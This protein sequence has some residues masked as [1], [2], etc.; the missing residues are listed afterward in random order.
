MLIINADDWGRDPLT[1]DRIHDCLRCGAVSAVSAMV[2]MEDSE[3]AANLAREGD[4][5][6]GLHLNFTTGFTGSTLSSALVEH[7]ARVSRY[8][9]KSPAAT[10]V[11]HPGLS[12]SFAYLVEVQC[13]EYARLYGKFPERL[14]GHHHMHLSANVLL[15]KLLPSGSMVRRSFSF[16]RGEK[17]IWNRAWRSLVN[18]MLKRRHRVADYFFS[19]APLEPRQRLEAIFALAADSLIELETHPVVPDEYEYLTGGELFRTC[20]EAAIPRT[21]LK[22]L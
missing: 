6:A 5:T 3:R 19:I 12:N 13:D 20:P 15:Q 18:A 1:T 21:L 10:V 11:Y 16:R 22:A 4:I 8:L 7:H 2:F 9:L 17:P 14:D